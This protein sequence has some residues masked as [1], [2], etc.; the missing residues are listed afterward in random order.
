MQALSLFA[1]YTQ[2]HSGFL[3]MFKPSDLIYLDMKVEDAFK[4]IISC[5]VISPGFHPISKEE[6]LPSLDSIETKG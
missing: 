1:Y 6:I 3:I 5:G 4:Y 2:S